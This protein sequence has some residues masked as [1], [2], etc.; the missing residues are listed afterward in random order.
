MSS[1]HKVASVLRNKQRSPS[2]PCHRLTTPL[3]APNHLNFLPLHSACPSKLGDSLSS[4][5]GRRRCTFGRMRLTE[6]PRNFAPNY[7][8]RTSRSGSGSS[9]KRRRSSA[10]S[11]DKCPEKQKLERACP[12]N[13]PRVAQGSNDS[14]PVPPK[15]FRDTKR[16]AVASR[17]VA[18]Q[19]ADSVEHEVSLWDWLTTSTTTTTA[20]ATQ[21]SAPE[22]L[23]QWLS[24]QHEKGRNS[25]DFSAAFSEL[26]TR[27]ATRA[28]SYLRARRQLSWSNYGI[29]SRPSLS[30]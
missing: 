23:Q 18:V 2:V 4:A 21:T 13:R 19:T 10:G 1:E 12:K 5:T 3:H 30:T 11:N 29:E 17:S 9:L 6:L 25:R 16:A 27:F 22:T 28:S 26:W 24:I 8:K 20:A 7:S 15:G 14:R